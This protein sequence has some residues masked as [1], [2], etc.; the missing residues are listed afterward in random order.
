MY[1]GQGPFK[2]KSKIGDTLSGA[3][4]PHAKIPDQ[5]NQQGKRIG[6]GLEHKQTPVEL[7]RRRS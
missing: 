5:I 7:Q 3:L 1:A 4:R 2:P 6:I